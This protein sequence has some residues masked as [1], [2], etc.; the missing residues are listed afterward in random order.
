[1]T[2]LNFKKIKKYIHFFNI[3]MKRKS[4]INLL[5]VLKIKLTLL[6][7]SNFEFY[8]NIKIRINNLYH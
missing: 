8:I 1:M 5:I 4:I 7:K 6:K 3:I 2:F